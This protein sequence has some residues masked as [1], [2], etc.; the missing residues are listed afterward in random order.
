MCAI[1]VIYVIT[2]LRYY[3]ITLLRY[4]VI[5]LLRYYVITLLRYYVIYVIT[6]D[7][8][9]VLQSIEDVVEV[10]FHAISDT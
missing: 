9:Q 2:L 4:Y 3:V 6:F 8:L 1:Y 10:I 5:T 7:N